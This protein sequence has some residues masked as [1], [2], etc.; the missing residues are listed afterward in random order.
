MWDDVG[1]MRDEKGLARA[2]AAL[3]ALHT[4]LLGTGIVEENRAFNMS[5]HEWLNLRSLCEI[6]RVIALAA[7]QR[8]N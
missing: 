8:K 1:I 3:A 5:W 2:T 7:G 6:S 4:E